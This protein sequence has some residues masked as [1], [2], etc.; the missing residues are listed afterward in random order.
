MRRTFA[1]AFPLL[2]I[3]KISNIAVI[4]DIVVFL[5][6]LTTPV[7]S[8]GDMTAPI[9]PNI[10][11]PGYGTTY[12]NAM[13]GNAVQGYAASPMVGPYYSGNSPIL[14]PQ[15]AIPNSTQIT[16]A[17]LA[18][19]QSTYPQ[20]GPGYTSGMMMPPQAIQGYGYEMYGM[21]SPQQY[22]PVY[23]PLQ[24]RH[25]SDHQAAAQ[26]IGQPSTSS[27]DYSQYTLLRSP[28]LETCWEN[29][30]LLSP[31]NAPDGPHRGV[32]QPLEDES[33]LDRPY[34][35]GIFGGCVS[36]DELIS[37]QIDQKSGS[38][39]GIILGWNL[40]HYWGVEGRLFGSS[41]DIK[42]ISGASMSER[43]SRL[44]VLDVSTHYYPYGEAKWRPYFKTGIGFAEERFT[45][46][47]N[48]K[49]SLNTWTVP[50]GVGIKYRWSDR[51]NVYSEIVDNVIFGK[52]P[53]RTHSNIAFNFGVCFTFGSNPN[54][55]P[56]VYWPQTP[57][58]PY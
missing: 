55:H 50:L 46:N 44:T 8:Q 34:Y 5:L 7:F 25:M 38:N 57:S 43:N 18:Y 11:I 35:F 45:D 17:Q 32:G 33:W 14:Q 42:D 40:S 54:H 10:A 3:A 19:L 30:K 22:P 36:G 49:Q 2:N 58:K 47:H 26:V 23:D 41:I 37:G 21:T 29:A 31:F 39:G 4:C 27:N 6:F 12:N 15:V 53:T 20:N 13:Y 56:T 16:A 52:G 51:V 9:A 48:R 24:G 28:L 1:L